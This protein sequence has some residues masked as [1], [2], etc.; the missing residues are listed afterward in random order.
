MLKEKELRLVLD[1]YG[2]FLGM[3]KGCFIVRDKGGAVER[4]PLFEREIGQ[5]VLKSGNMVSVGALASL[6]FWGVDVVVLTM[7]GKPVATVKSLDDESYVETRLYQYE[8]VSNGKGLYAAKEILLSRM[9]GQNLVF[10]KY[11]LEL[12]DP[13]VAD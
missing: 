8:A 11:G 13:K 12:H 2:S 10:S 7:K 3:E 1:G 4:Y 5:V 9:K 6:G